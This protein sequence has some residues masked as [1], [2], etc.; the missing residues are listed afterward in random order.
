[1]AMTTQS[2][3]L[4]TEHLTEA[5][6]TAFDV[7]RERLERRLP[8]FQITGVQPYNENIIQVWLEMPETT[9]YQKGLKAC[10]IAVDVHDETGICIILR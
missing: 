6:A 1:M 8:D 5:Q 10:K 7:F 3:D 9:T 4:M 2:V